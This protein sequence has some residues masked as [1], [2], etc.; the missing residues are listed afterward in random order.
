ML[1]KNIIYEFFIFFACNFSMLIIAFIIFIFFFV[2]LRK[3][4]TYIILCFSC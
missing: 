3:N 1:I 4:F 2:V